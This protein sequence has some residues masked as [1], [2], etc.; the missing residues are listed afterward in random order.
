[1]SL[2][3][4]FKGDLSGAISAAIIT[5]PMSIGYG[6]IVFAPLGLLFSPQAAL[7]GIYAATVTGFFAALFGAAPIQITGP[8]APLTLVLAYA[9]AGFAVAIP[10]SGESREITIVALAALCVFT[11]GIFQTLFGALRF[12]NLIKYIPYHVMAG[13]MNGIAIILIIKQVRPLTGTGETM[14]LSDPAAWLNAVQPLTLLV[15]LSTI[16]AIFMS[17]KLTN[18]IPA[19]FVGLISGTAVYYIIKSS[20]PDT[21]LGPVIGNI[22][23]QLPSPRYLA[24]WFFLAKTT[25]IQAFIPRIIGTGFTLGII[26]T[27]ESLLSCV[28]SDNL[29]GTH[30]DSRK[31]LIGQGI[32]N[33]LGSFC[34][35]IYGAG[36]IPRSLANYKAGG[37]TR[38]SGMLCAIIILSLIVL[39]HPIVSQ[40]PLAVIAAIITVVAFGMFDGETLFLMRQ[41]IR[42]PFVQHTDILINLA[43]SVMV[44]VI[45]IRFNLIVA[46]GAGIA[47]A[48]AMFIAKMSNSIIRR[49]Y[50]G[51]TRRSRI[52]RTLE[53]TE[54]LESQGKLIM[55]LELHGPLFFGSADNLSRTIEKLMENARY[56]ILDMKRVNDIDMTGLTILIR[57]KSMLEIKGK[58]L[59][60]S[61]L[62]T[63]PQLADFFLRS[64]VRATLESDCL[65]NDTDIALERAE[66]HLLTDG[67]RFS[68]LNREY[69]LEETSLVKGF[70]ESEVELLKKKLV[71]KIVQQDEALFF[72]GD[73]NNELYILLRGSV[74]IKISVQDDN[75]FARLITFSPGV[76]FGEI[77]L[78]DGSP[79]SAGAWANRTS[80]LLFLSYDD[81]DHLC[82]SHPGIAIKMLRNISLEFSRNLRRL[83]NEVK[84]LE[85]N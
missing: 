70:T 19:S 13:F 7:L 50:D 53:H 47:L 60:I 74:S 26:G 10:E 64:G 34:G 58:Y 84:A 39:A 3:C 20:A 12:G 9:V 76:S 8:K 73:K 82:R 45:T 57:I 65:F 44:T 61:Y 37:R 14:V 54:L 33:I 30:H 63:N 22:S 16:V 51:L 62:D 55:V 81:F 41:S 35:S 48:S 36:S 38:L 59:F 24:E 40:I 23:A 27:M 56:C 43:V 31:E 71:R 68:N 72:E 5:L 42:K 25:D 52:M 6:L 78:L 85:S 69:S 18:R 15:G 28:T 1:M 11:G 67:F 32:G 80:E 17:R 66:D 46:V 2:F 79:R 29:T 75:R 49:Q 4:N 83:T 77:A 21:P